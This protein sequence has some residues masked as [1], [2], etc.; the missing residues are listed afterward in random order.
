M[1]QRGSSMMPEDTSQPSKS[2]EIFTTSM[3]REKIKASTVY[4]PPLIP[5]SKVRNRAKELAE[6]LSDSERIRTERRNAKST[7]GKYTGIGSG[8][9]GFGGTGQKS[10]GFGRED[11]AYGSY[12]GQVYGIPC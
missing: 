11:L 12:S 2:F 8:E 9:S 6:L 7:K 4:P 10:S 1:E 5:K 3:T